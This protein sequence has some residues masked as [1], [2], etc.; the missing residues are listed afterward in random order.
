VAPAPTAIASVLSA[1]AGLVF[2]LLV[3]RADR[4]LAA[5]LGTEAL[6]M[7]ILA[8][9]ALR[10]VQYE[11]SWPVIVSTA[12]VLDA[13]AHL[14]FLAT[15]DTPI[16]RALRSRSGQ[17]GVALLSAAIV[18][19]VTLRHLGL[20]PALPGFPNTDAPAWLFL[21]LASLF[22]VVA[23]LDAWRRTARGTPAHRRVTWFA[24]AFGAR[25]ALFGVGILAWGA[26]DALGLLQARAVAEATAAFAPAV[27]VTLLAYGILSTQLFDIDLRIK[28]GISR[29]TVATL[30]LVAIL[31]AAKV[32]EF[33]L[34]KTYGFVAGGVAAGAMLVLVP[35]LNKLGDK[36]ANAAMPSVQPTSDYVAF[37]K[38][39]VYRA[40]V[41]AAHETGGLG[42]KDRAALDRLG[43]K[44]GLKEADARAVERDVLSP[45]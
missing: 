15:L 40:A 2:A 25:G 11:G 27:M 13:A 10:G 34:N 7:G 30:C 28:A 42:E 20:T 24:I 41:E 37:K 45:A 12:L 33:Y 22:A 39:E 44:L 32:A 26:T 16:G 31:A 43:D 1:A 3:Y 35:R 23:S 6:V 9:T 5:L 38:L 18:A 4:R 14:V 17:A 21:G 29:S 36:V 8:Y 19:F